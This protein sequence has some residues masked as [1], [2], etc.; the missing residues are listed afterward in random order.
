VFHVKQLDILVV[1]AGHAG[2]EAAL[3]ASRLGASVAVVTLRRDRIAAMSCNPA[4]GGVGKGHLVREIDALGGAM[5]RVADATGI[6]FR[7]LNASRGPAVRATRCQSDSA[8]YGEAMAAELER[9]G[10]PVLE[11]EARAFLWNAGNMQGVVTATGEIRARA[12]IVTAGTFL[13]GCC[14]VGD[15]WFPGGRHGDL[16]AN[17]LSDSLRAIGV[18][19]GRFKTGTTPRLDGNTIGWARLQVQHGDDPRPS[20]SHDGVPSPLAQVACHITHTTAETH[21]VVQDNLHLSPLYGGIIEGIGPRYCPSL[22]DKV[23]RFA[24]KPTHQVFLEPEGLAT[25]RVYANGLSTSLP[26]EAQ[27]AFLRTIPGLENVGVEVWGYAVEYDYAPPQQLHASLMT[28]VQPGLFLAGQI[29][30]TSGYEEAAAQGLIAGVNAVAYLG[31]G[32]P[33]VVKRSDGY[34]GVLVD[35]LVT[36]GADEPYRMFTAR[37]EY[38]LHLRESNA[39][40]R[41]LDLAAQWNLLPKAR[42]DAARQRRAE[43]E[44]LGDALCCPTSAAVARQLDLPDSVVGQP[45][46][47]ALRN[48]KVTITSLVPAASYGPACLR[49]VEEELKYDGYLQRERVAIARAQAMDELPIPPLAD[50]SKLPGLSTELREKLTLI[51]PVSLGQAARIP[52]MTPAALSILQLH[53]RRRPAPADVAPS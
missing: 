20:F 21:R 22:E 35:D 44:R 51:R 41:L 43:R 2:C 11:S 9:A 40:D 25:R 50:F 14:Y 28:K 13:N 12:V 39:E 23:V 36:R 7:T 48:P 8:L 52:G 32:D 18:T 19:L 31:A 6:Q 37:A 29:N 5:G 38:R 17:A 34:L 30:G 46:A 4:I 27:L 33:F 1:G 47:V 45:L 3:A 10:V 15:E 53:A 16:A 24:D 26:K 49:A 42:L